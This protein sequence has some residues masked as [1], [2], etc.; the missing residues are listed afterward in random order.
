MDFEPHFSSATKARSTDHLKDLWFAS[1]VDA[2]RCG[3]ILNSTLFYFWF[4]VQGNCRN[5]AGPDIDAFPIGD[6]DMPAL[7]PAEAVFGR[8]M[9]D[10]KHHSRT[11]V[12]NY[13]HSGRVEYQEFYPDRSKPILDQI[14]CLLAE[15]YG[16]TDEELDFIINYDLKYRMGRGGGED[17]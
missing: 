3:A 14:D 16:F 17:E 7:A 2:K 15:H 6:M 13:A 8:L 11:R 10:L 9:A 1:E 4:T 5:V 12:Y